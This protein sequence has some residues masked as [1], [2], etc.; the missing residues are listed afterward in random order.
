MVSWIAEQNLSFLAFRVK[1]TSTDAHE[2]GHLPGTI[3][4]TSDV[5][6]SNCS[7]AIEKLTVKLRPH[8]EAAA[9]G[10]K[11][12]SRMKWAMMDKKSVEAMLER[13]EQNKTS[14]QLGLTTFGL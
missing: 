5:L 13:L 14:L 2:T 4:G 1:R 8:I 10:R 11:W 6:L 12:R 3:V 9:A 7:S